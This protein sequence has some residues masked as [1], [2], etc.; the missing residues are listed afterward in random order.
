MDAYPFEFVVHL[1]PT[2]IVTGLLPSKDNE[3]TP[4]EVST[5]TTTAN[6]GTESVDVP[7]PIPP[8]P[9][10]PRSELEEQKE[11]LLQALLSRNNVT[12][13]DNTKGLAGSLYYIVPHDRAYILPPTRKQLQA[14][15]QHHHHPTLSPSSPS[16]P[17]YPDGL[18]TPLWIKRHREV[19]PSVFI[20]FVDLWDR[21]TAAL[22]AEGQHQPPG[23]MEKGP[24][25]VID[26]FE[27]EHDVQLAQ[28]LLDRRKACQERNVK[29]AAVLMLQRAHMEDPLIED[30]LSFVRKSA[31][32]DSKNSFYVLPPSSHQELADFAVNLQRSQYEGSMT[33]YREQVKRHRKKKSG[34]PSTSSSVRPLQGVSGNTAVP[35]NQQSLSVQGW[36]L[37]YEFKMGAFSEFRQDIENA[38]KH[39]ETAYALLVDMFAVTSSITPGAPGLQARTRRWAEAKVLAD[40]LCLKICKFRLYLDTPSTALF[41]FRRHLNAFKTFSDSWRIGEDSFE[42]WAWMCKQYRAMGDLLD[43]GAKSGFK[44][45]IPTPG[46]VVYGSLAGMSEGYNDLNK[47]SGLGLGAGGFGIGTG[48]ELF[49]FSGSIGSGRG[50]GTH[51]PNAGINPMMVLQHAGYFYHQAAKCSVQ[52]RLRFEAAE[53]LYPDSNIAPQPTASNP[54]PPNLQTM[55]AERAI[56]HYGL[57]IELLTKSYEQFKKHKAGRMTLFLASEIAGCYYSAGKFEM[58]LKFFERI[59]KTYR[60]EGWNLIL[61]SILKWSIQC[62]KEQGLWENVVEYL[63]ELLSPEWND[64]HASSF[65]SEES[66]SGLLGND[67]T[68]HQEADEPKQHSSAKGHW[69]AQVNLD[70]KGN[71]TKVLEGLITPQSIQELEVISVTLGIVTDS[72]NVSLQYNLSNRNTSADAPEL[73]Q[74][75]LQHMPPPPKQRRRWLDVVEDSGTPTTPQ[76]RMRHLDSGRGDAITA[77]LRVLPRASNVE[78]KVVHRTPAFLDEFFPIRVKVCNHEQVAVKM[79]MALEVQAL[80]TTIDSFDSIVLDPAEALA[81][82]RAGQFSFSRRLEHVVLKPAQGGSESKSNSDDEA[83]IPV[84]AWGERM[85]YI[86]A[87]A[88]PTPRNVVCRVSYEVPAGHGGQK[89]VTAEKEHSFRV[90]FVPPFDAEAV[91]YPQNEGKTT[92][93]K[94]NLAGSNTNMDAMDVSPIPPILAPNSVDPVHGTILIPALTRE[95]RYLMTTRV[96]SEGPWP[97]QIQ[98]VT[99]V[100]GSAIEAVLEGGSG[101]T[102]GHGARATEPT[103]TPGGGLHPDSAAAASAAGVTIPNPQEEGILARN[104]SV[105]RARER[106][107]SLHDAGIHVEILETTRSDEIARLGSRAN[108]NES[109][110]GSSVSTTIWR[111]GNLTTLNHLIRVTMAD[112]DLVPDEL[113]IGYLKV[114]WRRDESDAARLGP[115][116]ESVVPLQPLMIHKEEL[117]MTTDLPKFAQ[118]NRPFSAKYT[119]HNPTNRMQELTMTIE[120]SEGM[121]YAGTMQTSFKILPF[122][123]HPIQMTCYPLSAGLVRLPRVKLVIKRRPMHSVRRRGGQMNQIEQQQ[124]EQHLQQQKQHL[125]QQQVVRIL[126]AVKMSDVAQNR[127]SEGGQ[128]A[129]HHRTSSSASSLTSAGTTAGTA[130][131]TAAAAAGRASFEDEAVV[132]FVKPESGLFV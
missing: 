71:H 9:V 29:F 91:Y 102:V 7:P 107:K 101:G 88:I 39:Y 28:E 112:R 72:W 37:R 75:T 118:V 54:F 23:Y 4:R 93:A 97:V 17:L 57:T 108:N 82:M 42:Y 76:L 109:Q 63:I 58:A 32:L 123:T 70:I 64:C 85:V 13:W 50:G 59:G 33:Y 21:K 55:N 104:Q 41:H 62:A 87:V 25:G 66:L 43:I 51:G 45:P 35:P 61:A 132:I 38:V 100:L 18:I 47:F 131:G 36:M 89:T 80:D 98:D 15:F 20:A 120:P 86:R 53:E 40:C 19:I 121:V 73:L 30:R 52:R 74:Q 1:Q 94:D 44:L 129:G 110:Q 48:G 49:S 69:K 14:S 26:P 81:A 10:Q 96:H 65:E 2:L 125:Q 106:K 103:A 79:R 128:T 3:G 111:S 78:I 27:R 116:S 84:G 12:P 90:V 99:L 119:V 124:Q 68:G 11:V 24:L 56:D 60:K 126:G 114:V 83:E 115:W 122:G 117:F 5:P 130:A 92:I 46:S 31:G 8:R 105:R 67:A 113:E 77:P 95:E 34:L 6:G 127:I 22:N 16:S